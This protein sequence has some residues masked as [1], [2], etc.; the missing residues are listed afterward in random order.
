[1][2]RLDI[3]NRSNDGFK[4]AE[5]DLKLRGPGEIFGSRQSGESGGGFA[6]IYADSKLLKAAGE[7]T[8]RL[9]EEDPDLEREENSHLKR[10]L[11]SYLERGG[12]L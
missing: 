8:R 5:E 4:I 10:I 12:C 2:E 7:S 9:L 1:A 3:L 11:E 6:D